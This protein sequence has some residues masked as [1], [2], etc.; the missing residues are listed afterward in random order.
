MQECV[1]PVCDTSRCDQRPEAALH[2]HMGKHITKRHRQRSWSIEKAVTCK[3]EGKMTS[4]WTTAKLKPALF[5]ANKLDNRPF[6]ESPTVY[7][8]KRVVSRHFH[9]HH[10]QVACPAVSIAVST[11]ERHLE[12]SCARSH[13]ELRPRL[14]GC[15]SDSMVRSQSVGRRLMAA[16][17]AREW[18]CDGSARAI[19]PNRRNRLDTM[20]QVTGDCPVL[21]LTSSFVTWAVYGIR[22]IRRKHHWS[23]A[24]RRQLVAAVILHVSAA[25]KSHYAQ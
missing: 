17:R 11:T 23:E 22:N 1:L 21:R 9:H 24:S 12:R 25:Y 3:H 7:W 14:V 18:S 5:R 19:C 6:S 10:H 13:A 4:L 15:R 8:G 2:W 16:W 20:V